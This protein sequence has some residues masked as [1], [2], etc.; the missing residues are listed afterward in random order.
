MEE[1]RRGVLQGK[2]D[3][4]AHPQAKNCRPAGKAPD[5]GTVQNRIAR[6]EKAD[7]GGAGCQK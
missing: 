6:R 4:R 5:G 3:R 7:T 1:E 2:I